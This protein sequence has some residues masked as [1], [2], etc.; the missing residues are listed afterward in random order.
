MI[1]N[2]YY[3]D[4]ALLISSTYIQESFDLSIKQ[5]TDIQRNNAINNRKNAFYDYL[6]DIFHKIASF[7]GNYDNV[8]T[9]MMFTASKNAKML[10]FSIKEEK[11][12]I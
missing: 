3:H 10:N 7:S 6:Y 11:E 8:I 9:S 12:G 4:I 1:K 2:S 5:K